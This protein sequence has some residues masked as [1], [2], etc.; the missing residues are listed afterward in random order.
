[1][2]VQERHAV[3]WLVGFVD[4]AQDRYEY[5]TLLLAPRADISRLIPLREK[6]TL[7][8]LVELG[9]LP[10]TIVTG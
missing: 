10:A 4:H 2:T 1:L 7:S 9:V 8:L 5:A 6:I 3:G